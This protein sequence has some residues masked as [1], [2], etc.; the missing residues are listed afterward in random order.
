MPGWKPKGNFTAASYSWS[1]GDVSATSHGPKHRGKNYFY[2][3]PDAAKSTGTQLIKVG[4]KGISGG[5]VH[6]TLSGWLGG[7]SSQR[8]RTVVTVT[9]ENGKGAALA[10]A[11]IGPVTA[12]QRKDTSEFLLR[13]ATGTVPA[14]TRNLQVKI[15]MTRTDGSDND[16][17]ADNLSLTFKLK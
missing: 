15:V 1:G 2:G 3:G 16:G 9:F 17:L 11:H 13:S 10:T 14:G 4:A 8:D 7:F 6:Y 12:K 5:K